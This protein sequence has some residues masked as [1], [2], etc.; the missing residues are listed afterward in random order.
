MFTESAPS[1]PNMPSLA[2]LGCISPCLEGIAMQMIKAGGH[3]IFATIPCII[4]IYI[5]IYL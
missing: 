3:L 5:Y 4:Y 1:I 2:S